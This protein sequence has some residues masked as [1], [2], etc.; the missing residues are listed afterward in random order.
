MKGLLNSKRIISFILCIF[1]LL[2]VITLPSIA[3]DTLAESDTYVLNRDGNGEPLYRYQSPCMIGY[4][5]NEQYGGNGVPIQAFIYTMYNSVTG[6]HFPTYCGDIH[7]TAVQGT[8]YRRVNLEDSSFSA[9]AAGRIRA[10]LQKGFYIIPIDGES[11]D[12]HAQRV[13]AK[14]AELAAASGAEGLTTG[15]AIA[16]TQAAIWKISHGSELS[17][18]KFCRYVFNPT[19]TK[20]GSLCSYSELRYKN[21]ELINSTIETAYNYLLS[22]EPVA[23]SEKTV[24]PSSFTDLN[25]PVFNENSDGSYD[26]TVSTTIDVQ[27]TA[28]DELTLTAVLNDSY[29]ASASLK[30]GRQTVTLTL[31]NVPASLI[32]ENVDL[33]ISGYQ[34][35][36]GY[37]FF[38]S[39][40]ARG[41]S[42]SMVGYDDSRLPVYAKVRAAED[43]I[44]NIEKLANVAVGNDSYENKPLS[45]ITFDIYP[46]A[47]M[48][49]YLSGEV[50]LPDA[51]DYT[52]PSL[53]DYS[54]TTDENGKASMNFLHHNLPDGVY[55]VVERP[56]PSIVAPI[57]PFYLHIPMTD[58]DSGEWVNEVTIKPK[59]DVKGGVYIEKDVVS[60][61]NDEASVNAY[62]AHTWIIGATVPEDISSG[63][64][65]V[66]T[67]TLDNRL[68]YLGNLMIVLEKSG[69]GT[70]AALTPDTDYKLTVTDLDSLSEDRP[71]DS[72]IVELTAAG[73]A[74]IADTVGTNDF[75][76][77]MLRVYFDAQINANAE[78]GTQIP[79]Q[80][81]I[82]YINAVNFDFTARSDKPVVYTGGANLLKVD[83]KNSSETLSGATF[84][85]YR[86]ATPEEVGANDTRLTEIAG[87]TGKVIKVSFFD[88]PELKGEKVTS[89][90]SGKDGSVGIYGLAYGKYYLAETKA[91]AGYNLL[92]EAFELTVNESSHLEKNTVKVENISGSILPSTGGIGTTVYTVGGIT[93]IL[94][95]L[96]LLILKKRRRAHR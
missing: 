3:E 78:M 79:N 82:E 71:G 31:K 13:A 39:E 96:T 26:I 2:S 80:A 45:G 53:P 20:Y 55:L 70:V 93:L 23:A 19:N 58:P 33:V 85:L 87:A 34:T 77:Y 16:A 43:R 65:Y 5:L 22:L 4:D 15:E 24:S 95:A 32:S 84:E 48:D 49:E 94:A 66:I 9:S 10:V 14:T 56:H 60:V 29:K 64:S 28:T 61:G 18:P 50:T 81:E 1:I 69:E 51:K 62:E 12:D 72:F 37:F 6:K 75:N 83:S 91:P 89:V 47:T 88:N 63:R 67:D 73:M 40:G 11:E 57:E 44:L 30:N 8:D 92:G 21:N 59:N 17:F 7:V 76:S 74:K 36:K 42:Q 35:V 27:I 52:Y 86:P 38:D 90:T 46:V 25:D 54:L 68:D 41:A